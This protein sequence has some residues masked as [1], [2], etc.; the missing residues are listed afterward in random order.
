MSGRK[1]RSGTRKDYNKMVEGE[2][3]VLSDNNNNNNTSEDEVRA[4]EM[5]SGTQNNNNG[6]LFTNSDLELDGGSNGSH[7]SDDDDE[8]LRAEQQLLLAKKEE[9]MLR[10]KEKLERIAE[11]MKEVERSVKSLRKK[12]KSKEKLTMVSLRKMD[13]VEAEVNELMDKKMNI[14]AIVSSEDSD[15]E[16]EDQEVDVR[17]KSS[18]RKVSS[19][20]GRGDKTNLSSGLHKSGKSKTLTSYVQFPQEW[21]HS[22]LS[23]NFVSRPKEY[24][25]LSIP[26]FCAGYAGILEVESEEV[27][28]H[29]R[30]H[31]KDL[32]Y[33]ATQYHWRNV[34]NFHAA[35]LL[36][37][38]RGNLTWGSDFRDLQITTLAGGFLNSYQNRSGNTSYSH[39]RS[40]SENSGVLFCKGYQKGTCQQPKDHY[41]HF[42]GNSRLLKHIC[43]KCWLTGKTQLNYPEESEQCP[44]NEK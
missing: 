40:S 8:I 12:S 41:G 28:H 33:L 1:L 16:R 15:E 7:S 3:Q 9:K 42:M 24:E 21:P 26:E 4:C 44:H 34:L 32:M 10:K 43:A 6:G 18:R 31:L 11:E 29:R 23:L 38:E 22:H 30:K 5:M 36:E 20:K 14:K 27:R 35:C 37:I 39:N 13:D 19:R 2:N 17:G 25:E